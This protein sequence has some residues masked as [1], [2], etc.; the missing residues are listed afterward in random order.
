MQ[1]KVESVGDAAIYS[2]PRPPE[3]ERIIA[4]TRSE[5]DSLVPGVQGAQC[6]IDMRLRRE[7]LNQLNELGA[8]V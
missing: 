8:S 2:D 4:T 5:L 1:Q 6:R 3:V 7:L